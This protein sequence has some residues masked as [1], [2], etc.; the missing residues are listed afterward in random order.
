VTAAD[1]IVILD[2][3]SQTTQ[4]IARR[5]REIGVYSEILPCTAS[6]DN[7]RNRQPKGLV[8]SGGPASVHTE[9]SPRQP[10]GIFE[11][12]IPLLGIC[13]GLQLMAVHFGG[14]V[15][16]SARHEYG[17]AEIEASTDHPLFH[18]LDT[19]Q[20]VWMSH[21]DRVDKLPKDFI[22]IAST[23]NS[24][25]AA[26]AHRHKPLI[27][28]QFHPEVAHTPHGQDMLENFAYRI[29]GCSGGWSPESFL[30]SSTLSLKE[31]IGDGRVL[32]GLSGGVDSSVVA[33]LIHRAVSDQLVCVFV[34]NGLLRH[35]ESQEVIRT[36]RDHF[37]INLQPVDA[38]DRFLSELAGVTEPEA[39]RRI[40]GRVFVEI[41]EQEAEHI[42]EIQFLAQGT[43][44]PDVIESTS[45]KG[46]SSTIKSHH[47]VGGLPETLKLKLIEPLRELFKDEVRKVGSLLGLPTA[48]VD[49]HPFPGPGL[50]VRVLGEVTADRVEIARQADRVFMEELHSSGWY[51][52]VSQALAVLLPVKSVGV[53]GDE[54]TY[55]NVVA[56]RAV[57]TRDYMTADV[58]PIPLDLLTKVATRITNEVPGVNRVVYDLTSKPPATVEWE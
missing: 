35:G 32:C 18:D 56:L 44:Y 40:V 8:L 46:P 36:F 23:S 9:G 13:Y 14:H 7:I 19:Q 55:Q 47:N 20:V 33:L 3:G 17:R 45:F 2:F 37:H 10:Q 6:L 21:R 54:R 4:L 11:L 58:S 41:F 12:G 42:G 38:A 43:I 30:E 51:P 48:L 57:D 27:G 16:A 24:P 5:I 49:R 29:C 34:D 28:V 31:K 39:K 15:D 25:I 50:S 26:I 53:M 1:H 52:K 22:G